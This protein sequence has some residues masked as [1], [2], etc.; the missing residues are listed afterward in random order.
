MGAR[1]SINASMSRSS[2]NPARYAQRARIDSRRRR[3]TQYFSRLLRHVPDLRRRP[4]R[5]R[6][7]GRARVDDVRADEVLGALL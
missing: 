3:T 7:A 2:P 6:R 4:G 5:R 1:S